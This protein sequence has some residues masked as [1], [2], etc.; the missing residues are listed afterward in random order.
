MDYEPRLRPL[1]VGQ[2]TPLL[3]RPVE[4]RRHNPRRPAA[5][6]N[7][8]LLGHLCELERTVLDPVRYCSEAGSTI[9][10]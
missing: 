1:S 7:A 3:G 2:A 9:R 10:Q 6:R 5:S 4:A 8:R